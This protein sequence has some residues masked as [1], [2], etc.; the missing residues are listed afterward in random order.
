MREHNVCLSPATNVDSASSDE[1]LV[2]AAA[3][4]AKGCIE[5]MA[6]PTMTSK[7]KTR[8]R[9]TDNFLDLAKL[10]AEDFDLVELRAE[11]VRELSSSHVQELANLRNEL[12]RKHAAERVHGDEK[13][14]LLSEAKLALANAQKENER[15][16]AELETNPRAASPTVACVE[17]E[18]VKNPRTSAV[19]LAEV[20][21]VTEQA[22]DPSLSPTDPPLSLAAIAA[23][24]A[25]LTITEPPRTMPVTKPVTKPAREDADERPVAEEVI[26]ES[27]DEV[28]SDKAHD[29]LRLSKRAVNQLRQSFDRLVAAWA[30]PKMEFRTGT[31]TQEADHPTLCGPLDASAISAA[32]ETHAELACPVIRIRSCSD[33]KLTDAMLSDLLQLSGA[34]IDK[35][36]PFCVLADYRF[37]RPTL[38]QTQ[39]SE[40]LKFMRTYKQKVDRLDQANALVINNWILKGIGYMMLRAVPPAQP[41]QIFTTTEEAMDFLKTHASTVCVG[42]A[43]G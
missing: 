4:A 13:D 27:G 24:H 26:P 42:A 32:V 41:T 3:R 34:I 16:S 40:T 14:R 19:A 33:F 6:M 11:V 18:L 30:L 5:K 43:A 15:L 9:P 22:T 12:E 23:A 28:A 17:A 1:S 2:A 20:D 35:D 29:R 10:R 8:P 38:S 25:F 31:F 37:L 36:Q 21:V 7:F 39:I